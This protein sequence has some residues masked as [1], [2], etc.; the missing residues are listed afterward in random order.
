MKK[1]DKKKNL[2][3]TFS[4]AMKSIDKNRN[5][6]EFNE[7]NSSIYFLE[8]MNYADDEINKMMSSQLISNY[9]KYKTSKKTYQNM[10]KRNKEY[11]FKRFLNFDALK[12]KE[13]EKEDKIKSKKKIKI[14][15]LFERLSKIKI[16]FNNANKNE[17]KEENIKSQKLLLTSHNVPF[18]P[19]INKSFKG[20]EEKKNILRYPLNKKSN[21]EELFSKTKFEN[22]RYLSKNHNKDETVMENNIQRHSNKNFLKNIYNQCLNRIETFE[23]QA[24]EKLK[25][26][27]SYSQKKEKQKTLENSL[28]NNDE[29][30]NKYLIEN[31]NKFNKNNKKKKVNIDKQIK[32][33]KLKRDPILK[34]SP[35]FAYKNR[36]PLL[37]LFNCNNEDE[38]NINK[39]NL[40]EELTKKDSIILKNLEKDNRNVNLLMKRL[41]EDQIKYK[42][43]GY[44]FMT[45]ENEDELLNLQTKKKE[46]SKKNKETKQNIL[47]KNND[48]NNII[49]SE[50]EESPKKILTKNYDNN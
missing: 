23:S 32:D 8:T 4:D 27:I 19:K 17:S 37:A 20:K 49:K 16:N 34:L 7:M 3:I 15:P 21:L 12:K 26:K 13:K 41:D 29:D 46:Y 14:N 42:K 35:E 36:K 45:E 22:S 18:F 11:L 47:T 30:M 40:Y 31:I 50:N 43:G 48:E 38:D 24:Q 10:L 6:N 28:Y 39:K 25:L 1:I 9:N 5:Y 33:M 44:Y 2:A